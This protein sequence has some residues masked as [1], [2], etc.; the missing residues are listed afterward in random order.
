[1]LLYGLLFLP[2]TGPFYWSSSSSTDSREWIAFGRQVAN[3][4]LKEY[5]IWRYTRCTIR[6]A[7]R[8]G[9]SIVRLLWVLLFLPAA[10]SK[11]VN[12]WSVS[13]TWEHYKGRLTLSS[14]VKPG[15]AHGAGSETNY[16]RLASR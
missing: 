11:W 1:M 16:I 7:S 14:N 10:I 2:A 3:N 8:L 13:A 12:Y 4:A 9:L 5:A 15:V 6:L